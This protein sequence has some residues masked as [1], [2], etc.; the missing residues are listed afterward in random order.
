[1]KQSKVQPKK[2]SAAKP[3]VV[4]IFSV[5]QVSAKNTHAASKPAGRLSFDRRFSFDDNGGGYAG[6]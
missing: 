5:K 1:M 3:V 6:L 2:A 4:K